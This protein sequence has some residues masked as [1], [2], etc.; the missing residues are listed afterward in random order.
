MFTQYL[1]QSPCHLVQADSYCYKHLFSSV[2]YHS[3]Y[4]A[5]QISTSLTSIRLMSLYIDESKVVASGTLKGKVKT[6]DQHIQEIGF[7]HRHS[8]PDD[9]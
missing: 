3:N 9:D 6:E 2:F 4:L 1:H 5:K 8:L 7:V